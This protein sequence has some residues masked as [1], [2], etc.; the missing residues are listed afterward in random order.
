MAEED[1]KFSYGASSVE[2]RRE[3]E[4]GRWLISRIRD[5]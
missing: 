3:D 2:M 5:S 4:I 1:L